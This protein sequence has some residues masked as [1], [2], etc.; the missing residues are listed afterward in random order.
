MR[1]VE[2]SNDGFSV[3]GSRVQRAEIR[4]FTSG[5]AIYCDDIVLPRMVHLAFLRSPHA[6]ARI[7]SIDADEARQMPGVVG[8]FTGKEIAEICLPWRGTATHRPKLKS[9]LQYPVAIDRAT[10]QGEPVVAVAA[11]T[12]AEAEDAIE[13]IVVDFEELPAVVDPDGA[14][15][16]ESPVIHPDLGDNLADEQ[17]MEKGDV[18]AAFSNASVVVEHHFRFG[19][20]TGVT[21]EPRIIISSFERQSGQLTVYQ[22]HQSPFQTQSFLSTHLNIPE[23]LVRVVAP[24]VGGAFGVKLHVYGDE[25]AA[26][27][28]SVMLGRPVKFCADRLES[29]VSD[30]HA[31]DHIVTARVALADDGSIAGMEVD[32]IAAVGPY[33]HP[34]RFSVVEGLQTIGAA[35]APYVLGAYRGRTRTVYQNKTMVGMYRGVGLPLAC[36]ITETMM[37]KAARA[38][39]EDP[40]DFRLRTYIQDGMFP[41]TSATGLVFERLSLIACLEQLMARMN[42]RAL[43]DEQAEL[44]R[45]GVQR[46]IGLSTFVEPTAYGARY[47]GPTGAAVSVQ[48]GATVKLEPS[49]A[50]RVLTSATDQ[51]QGTLTAI[52]QIVAEELGIGPDELTILSGDSATTPYGGGSWASRGAAMA[53]EAALLAARDLKCNIFTLAAALL[54]VRPEDLTLRNGTISGNGGASLTLA[55]IGRVGHFRQDT[56]PPDVQP[57]LAVTRSFLPRTDQT[58]YF[59]ANGVQGSLVELDAE[60]GF[61]K[62]LGHW[63]VD[64]C[65]R[66]INPLLVDEQIRGGIVQGIGGALF[67]NCIYDQNGQMKNASM[68]DYLVPMSFEMPDIDV[69]HVATPTKLSLLGAKG[70]GEAGTI[71]AL[72]ALWSSVND[73]LHGLGAE[74]TSQPFTPQ[75]ILDALDAVAPDRY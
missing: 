49:G 27:A 59:V 72:G 16:L 28:I 6:H 57:Q 60:T 53:G 23:H 21:L 74:V 52:R 20:Q 12:R 30:T 22:A 13:T 5:S 19:R 41:F 25:V 35:G 65:G 31:R 14:L 32:D 63:A 4:N 2:K 1:S 18:E 43:R 64:D 39:G 26:A 61:I 33:G 48:E 67:E 7:V 10:W 17:I 29:F 46:G 50:I 36:A 8:V 40:A 55:E 68:A 34:L 37:D 47:Y 44:R 71:G 3:I 51:G 9:A 15:E 58:P 69:S 62:L 70:V 54:Q 42:Y 24:N 38:L 56:L 73:A 75:T 66:V 45:K 11:Q